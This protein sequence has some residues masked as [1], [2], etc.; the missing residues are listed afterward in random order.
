LGPEQAWSPLCFSSH[1]PVSIRESRFQ[2]ARPGGT[3]FRGW[4]ECDQVWRVLT[5]MLEGTRE[6]P[7]VAKAFERVS[8]LVMTTGG[9]TMYGTRVP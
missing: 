9:D 7:S 1:V 5:A 2:R 6:S 8:A 3:V 4:Q